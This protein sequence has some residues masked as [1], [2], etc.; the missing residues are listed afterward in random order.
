MDTKK[1]MDTANKL[2]QDMME[3]KNMVSQVNDQN[4]TSDKDKLVQD[5]D[6]VMEDV[7]MMEDKMRGKM[8][9]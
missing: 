6:M 2:K 4:M 3:M 1:M 5:M 8:N 7:K 9:M